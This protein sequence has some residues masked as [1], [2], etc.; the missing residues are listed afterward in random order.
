MGKKREKRLRSAE[1]QIERGQ[2]EKALIEYRDILADNPEDLDILYKMSGLQAQLGMHTDAAVSLFQAGVVLANAEHHLRAVSTFN[3]V[4]KLDPRQIDAVRYLADLTMKLGMH[5]E[6][7]QHLQQLA[8]HHD[9][10]GESRQ[11][12]NVYRLLADLD[13]TNVANLIKLGE[14]YSSHEKNNHA[15]KL[16]KKAATELKKKGKLNEYVKVLERLVYID[17][18]NINALKELANI[19]IQIGEHKKALA[20]L[21]TAFRMDEQDLEVLELLS[22]LFAATGEKR[23]AI[24]ALKS[25]AE[26]HQEAYALDKVH[27]VYK[28]VL[29]LDPGDVDARTFFGD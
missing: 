5:D 7:R 11:A 4:L 6:A 17:A 27:A 19:Y 12:L 3:A 24:Q 25:M 2:Y 1:R 15:I 20:R 28:R 9:A 22:N 23:K 29:E 10:R 21:Q 14:L 16:F 8:L 13:P 18:S 26:I